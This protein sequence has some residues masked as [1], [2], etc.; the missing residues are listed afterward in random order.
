MLAYPG[1]T[2]EL[3]LVTPRRFVKHLTLYIVFAVF[4][5]SFCHADVTKLPAED[6]KVLQDISR[7]H[8]IHSTSDLSPVI[9]P[10]CGGDK[11][12]EPG[13]KWSD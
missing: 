10:L 6:R 4:I 2:S 11:L 3:D 12:A 8:E 13:Q 1:A 7:F 5:Q 9:I